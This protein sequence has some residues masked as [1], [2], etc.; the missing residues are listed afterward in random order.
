MAGRS[1]RLA[2]ERRPSSIAATSVVTLEGV[3]P[4][5]TKSSGGTRP[6]VGRSP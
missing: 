3:S 6:N 5:R 2:S 1:D 4:S